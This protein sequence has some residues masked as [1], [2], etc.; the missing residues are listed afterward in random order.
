MDYV[1]L[2]TAVNQQT[3]THTFVPFLQSA[4][5]SVGDTVSCP[6][7][8]SLLL[9]LNWVGRGRGEKRE[10][11]CKQTEAQL[12]HRWHYRPLGSYLSLSSSLH[13]DRTSVLHQAQQQQQQQPQIGNLRHCFSLHWRSFVQLAVVSLSTSSRC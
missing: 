10:G 5:D 9:L 12:A 7:L 3:H 6:G 4:G 13:A 2:L 8:S 1:T 11:S